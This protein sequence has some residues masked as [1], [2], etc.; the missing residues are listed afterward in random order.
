[1]NFNVSLSLKPSIISESHEQLVNF[2]RMKLTQQ[3]CTTEARLNQ[4]NEHQT[5]KEMKM[6]LTK[7]MRTKNQIHNT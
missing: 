7:E 5:L 1:M 4:P 3:T 2:M 6:K